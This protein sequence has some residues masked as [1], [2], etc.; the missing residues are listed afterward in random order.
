M[1]VEIEITGGEQQRWTGRS[2][3]MGRPVAELRPICIILRKTFEKGTKGNLKERM[4]LTNPVS[5]KRFRSL[6]SIT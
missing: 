6:L 4:P 5:S 3:P 1:E 2:L